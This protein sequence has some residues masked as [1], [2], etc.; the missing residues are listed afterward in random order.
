MA[1]LLRVDGADGSVTIP[2]APR[3]R[4]QDEKF[5]RRPPNPS[6][7]PDRPRSVGP[8]AY[9]ALSHSPPRAEILMPSSRHRADKAW[10]LALTAFASFMISLDSQVV[11]TVL[12]TIRTDLGASMELLEWTVN[13]YILSFAVLLLA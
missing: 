3:I 8:R 11:T 2:I 12:N 1:S 4:W 6:P 13:A 5:C 10:V 7:P 9:K